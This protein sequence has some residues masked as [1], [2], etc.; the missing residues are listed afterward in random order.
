MAQLLNTVPIVLIIVLVASF[1]F[2]EGGV[3]QVLAGFS[4]TLNM[5][6]KYL[7]PIA[8]MFLISGQAEVLMSNH[9]DLVREWLSGGRG[10]FAAWLAAVA[11][12]GGGL[13]VYPLAKSLWEQHTGRAAIMMFLVSASLCNW[14]V[15]MF[16]QPMLGWSST[17]HLMGTGF[18]VSL[19]T[20]GFLYAV[21]R[22][23]R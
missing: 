9:M 19:F 14:Q 4:A 13:P 11:S 16:R 21:Q 17:L 10:M 3:V 6:T 12:P 2:H 20:G 8:L 15:L 1:N 5:F 22:F 7:A 18:A 23:W